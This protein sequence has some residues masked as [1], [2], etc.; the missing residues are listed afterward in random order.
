MKQKQKKGVLQKDEKYTMQNFIGRVKGTLLQ[1][2]YTNELENKL[3]HKNSE[4]STAKINYYRKM[5]MITTIVTLSLYL[6]L[7]TLHLIFALVLYP[8][9]N[10]NFQ[11]TIYTFFT[12]S[13]LTN[14]TKLLGSYRLWWLIVIIPL[15][16]IFFSI[17][18][19]LSLY[20]G[21][22]Y[23]NLDAS[24]YINNNSNHRDPPK[25]LV[26]ILLFGVDRIMWFDIAIVDGLLIWCVAQFA[27][28]VDL[29]LLIGL[30]ILNAIYALAGGLGTEIV[31]DGVTANTSRS[32][33]RDIKTINEENRSYKLRINWWPLIFGG[34]LPC[35]IIISILFTFMTYTQNSINKG[36]YI[37]WIVVS[38]VSI[39]KILVLFIM[40]V[41]YNTAPLDIKE[42]TKEVVEIEFISRNGNYKM[43]KLIF[44]GILRITVLVLFFV[45]LFLFY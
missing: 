34:L 15:A 26:E 42:T 11:G 17:Y 5:I 37:Q 23:K 2:T 43:I 21:I 16:A 44:S 40:F 39:A 14:V 28:V 1:D 24:L 30:V 33:I 9:V 31:N 12:S 36:L 25:Y 3:I 19:I 20:Y 35:L 29:M 38:F 41:R 45:E 18:T 22:M 7:G 8:N 27:G 4:E 10:N 6:V 13:T 32:G